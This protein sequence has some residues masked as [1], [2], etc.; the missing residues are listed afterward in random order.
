MQGLQAWGGHQGSLA[1]QAC[2]A[3]WAPQ[4]PSVSQDPKEKAALWGHQDRWAPKAN[5]ACRGSQGS[6]AFLG[7]WELPREKQGTRACRG[8]QVC[9]GW[10]GQRVSRGCLVPRAFRAPQASQASQGPVALL[11]P[12]GCQ[13]PR[14]N[15]ANPVLLAF[16]V[17]EN[18][19]LQ[20]CRALQGSLGHLVPLASRACRGLPVPLGH[21]DPQ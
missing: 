17:L 13:G 5:Q 11:A 12:Q 14:G 1:N 20:G 21:L 16:L 7:K 19:E 6:Q 9:Q 3:S 18:L 2:Q 10:W 15:L 4:V 8:Y